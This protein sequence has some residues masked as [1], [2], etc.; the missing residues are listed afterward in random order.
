MEQYTDQTFYLSVNKNNW[1][2]DIPRI[3][4]NKSTKLWLGKG[5]LFQSE[6]KK[7]L[8]ALNDW[9]FTDKV[10]EK[11]W[12]FGVQESLIGRC[13]MFW[14]LTKTGKMSLVVPSASFNSRVAKINEQEQ[15]AEIFYMNEQA[16]N[17]S[18]TWVTF[19]PEKVY[20]QIY[21][22]IDKETILGST[23]SKTK[24][25]YLPELEYSLDNPFGYLPIVEIINMPNPL[26]F[27]NSTTLNAYPDCMPVYHLIEDLNQVIKQKRK[28]RV[29]NQTR[30]Y[31]KL[32]NEKLLDLMLGNSDISEFIKDTFLEVASGDYDKTGKGNIN[33]IQGDPKFNEYWLDYN[34]TAKQIFNGAGYDYDE[35]GS[36]V[37]TNKTQSMF[38]NKYDMET[39]ETKIAYYIPY[40]M[41]M[42][43]IWV[44]YNGFWNGK[45]ERPYS[46]K[47]I[48]IAMT[49]QIVQDQLINSRLNNGTMSVTE[50]IGEYDNID[51]LMANNKLEEIIKENKYL[52]KNL[53]DEKN[54]Q[55]SS[56]TTNETRSHEIKNTT[57]N[58]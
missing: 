53:G 47:F 33:I 25:D 38:N 48:P 10:F 49:D 36:D 50:A 22:S 24:P 55:T 15:S 43:D 6:D 40:I 23:R 29:L 35:H 7:L 21:N 19:T 44:T 46:F 8:D 14:Q 20:V 32:A 18:I 37:Y 31:G 57:N 34:G 30:I 52:N 4:A 5:I 54:E 27:G 56:N 42:I 1:Y 41:R 12:K 28:E 2:I 11:L 51:P 17:T 3:I 26:L 16:D 58:D 45:G 13:L 9:Y 39:T